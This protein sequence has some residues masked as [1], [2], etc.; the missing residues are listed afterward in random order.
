MTEKYE[1]V[2]EKLRRIAYNLPRSLSYQD[3]MEAGIKII[4]SD[5]T[6]GENKFPNFRYQGDIIY[7]KVDFLYEIPQSNNLIL[8]DWKTGE[9]D[10]VKD[11]EQLLLYAI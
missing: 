1:K 6:V 7:A 5:K 3:V 8:V 4:L 11:K 9:K 2:M 10:T